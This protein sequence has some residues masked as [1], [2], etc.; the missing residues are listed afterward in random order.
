MLDRVAKGDTV[1]VPDDVAETFGKQ[2]GD[3]VVKQ[4]T[5]RTVQAR[6]GTKRLRPS[7]IGKPCHRQLWF[8]HHTPEVGETMPG[9][10]LV[11]FLFGDIIESLALMLAKLAGHRVEGEQ[12]KVEWQHR[13]WTISGRQD[14]II[15]GVLVDVKSASGR[16]VE[17]FKDGLDDENDRF[18][19]R[20]QLAAYYAG[21]PPGVTAMGFLVKNKENG[22]LLWSPQPYESPVDKLNQ[23]IDDLEMREPP[24]RAFE[25]VPEG[26][27]G[28]MRLST[29]CS[30]CPFKQTCWPGVRGF[31]Y[32]K[33]PVWLTTVAKTPDVP[34]FTNDAT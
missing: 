34:E 9:H 23:L 30:Y 8:E 11:K 15:D 25:P 5:G 33:G 24:P 32:S 18:G 7:E 20:A 19:Y 10:T 3:A 29:E 2:V 21:S 22:R 14:A 26:K 12:D 1:V 13:G 28:N 17:K 16:G 27:S 4:L 31:A 6:T